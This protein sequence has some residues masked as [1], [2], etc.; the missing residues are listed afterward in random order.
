MFK[1][2]GGTPIPEGS[3][4]GEQLRKYVMEARERYGLIGNNNITDEE[5][6]QALYKHSKELG[7]NTAAVNAQG[8]P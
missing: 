5:I 7:G 6:A 8:E 2:Y 4:N 1:E 3:I